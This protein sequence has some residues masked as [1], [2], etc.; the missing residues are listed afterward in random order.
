MA[1][2]N[3]TT[4][5]PPPGPRWIP[6]PNRFWRWRAIFNGWQ[7][8][9]RGIGPTL[10]ST[11]PNTA[12]PPAPEQ[13]QEATPIEANGMY[14]GTTNTYELPPFV[15]RFLQVGAWK[16]SLVG[17]EFAASNSVYQQRRRQ[18]KDRMH[19]CTDRIQR[20]DAEL[21]GVRSSRPKPEDLIDID[22]AR[23]D[24]AKS[25]EVHAAAAVEDLEP[26]NLEELT[27]VLQNRAGTRAA[28]AAEAKNREALAAHERA[29]AEAEAEV[30]NW[31]DERHAAAQEFV[32]VCA[33]Q[34]EKYVYMRSRFEALAGF[35]RMITDI[36]WAANRRARRCLWRRIAQAVFGRWARKPFVSDPVTASPPLETP[37]WVTENAY[38]LNERLDAS[39]E[40]DRG[41]NVERP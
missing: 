1:K 18:A 20:A 41:D 30:T 39:N 13:N 2:T 33:E 22:T 27:P 25:L 10:Q 6:Y 35:T 36:Y 31:R 28:T 23:N 12:R 17:Q 5:W 7:D 24:A 9:R 4:E 14:S 16:V 15:S 37:D 40:S 26:V 3:T 19:E 29:A 21:A 38:L 8:G 34:A 11:E 32:A